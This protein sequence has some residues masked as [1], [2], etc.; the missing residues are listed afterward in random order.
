MSESPVLP[1]LPPPVA[2]TNWVKRHIAL[3]L[4]TL[5]V[6]L[7]VASLSVSLTERQKQNG[8]TQ[9]LYSAPADLEQ[10]ILRVK[11]S[12][13]TVECGDG[14]GSGWVTNLDWSGIT[15]TKLRAII[16]QY[17]SSVITNH[18]VIEDCIN[19][20]N[21]N[22]SVLLGATGLRRQ[23]TI[24][25]WDSDN[26]LALILVDA[27]LKPVVEASE[28]PRGGWW[29]MA[30]GS[31]WEFNSSVSIGNVI[32]TATESTKSDIISSAMLNPGNSGGPLVNSRGEVIGTNTWRVNDKVY[33]LY[34][35]SVGNRA[36]CDLLVECD[37]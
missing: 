10:L 3:I 19:D 27:E 9:S 29:T 4:G 5:A 14:I 18:H 13:V 12:L 28:T 21:L 33:G 20:P 32:S 6:V 2:G 34:Y 30:I 26:D 11:Q 25:N 7:S 35:I 15:E 36:I 23:Y 22:Q 8:A 31:P 16:E 24:W 37:D 17:P 1:Q